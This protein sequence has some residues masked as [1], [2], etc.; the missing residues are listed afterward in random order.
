LFLYNAK[1]QKIAKSSSLEVS[2]VHNL[3]DRALGGDITF[4]PL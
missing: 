3:L 2:S 4:V 1:K